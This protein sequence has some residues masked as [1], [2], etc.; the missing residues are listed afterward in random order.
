MICYVT[1]CGLCNRD[2]ALGAIRDEGPTL[3]PHR[4]DTQLI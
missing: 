1:I 3:L 2:G 4:L